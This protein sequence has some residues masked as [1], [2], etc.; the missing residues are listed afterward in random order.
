MVSKHGSIITPEFSKEHVGSFDAEIISAPG[1]LPYYSSFLTEKVLKPLARGGGV[2][3]DGV[4]ERGRVLGE[5]VATP[6]D[7]QPKSE[8]TEDAASDD[9][10]SE[11]S[12]APETA[13]A[14][15][16]DSEG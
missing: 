4:V 5:G 9:G 12:E 6:S 15:A 7:L 14:A 8:A 2:R 16:G 3:P 11:A 13:E 10:E 1:D